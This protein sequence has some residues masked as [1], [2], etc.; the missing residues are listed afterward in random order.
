MTRNKQRDIE[1]TKYYTENGWNV[2]RVWEHDLKEN[3]QGTIHRI[4][5]FITTSINFRQKKQ[6]IRKS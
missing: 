6:P 3:F 2:L 5:E 4:I 1:T